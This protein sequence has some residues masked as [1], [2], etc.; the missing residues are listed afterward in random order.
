VFDALTLQGAMFPQEI[1]W[2][3]RLLPSQVDE[4]LAELVGED[5]SPATRSAG[6]AR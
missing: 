2:K 5:S 1:A 6:C 3:T 4:G